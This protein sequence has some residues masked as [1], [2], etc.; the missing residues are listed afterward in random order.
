MPKIK[1]WRPELETLPREELEKLQL[2]HFR[3]QMKYV[4]EKSPFYR[5]KF[6]AAGVTPDDIK[7]MDDVRRVPFTTKQELLKSQEE[8]P[9]FGDFPCIRPEQATRV[10]Q[11][12]GTTG[13][14]LKIPLSKK[15][16]F[17]TY[18]EQFS[19]YLCGYGINRKDV[20]F[21]PFT[22]GTFIAWWGVQAV[23][24][25]HGIT[26][27]PGGGQTSDA[28]VKSIV[29]WEATVVCGT[30][31]YIIYLGEL[32]KKLG[33][34]LP[35]SKVRVVITAG[36]PGAQVAATKHLVESLYGAKNYDDIGST[37]ISNFGFECVVQKGTH[38]VESMFLPESLD[39]ETLKPVTEGEVG[40]LVLS[41]LFC[42][43]APLLRYM[44][45][46]LVRFNYRK[47]DC[48]R[49][50][51]RMDGGVLGRADDMF[52]FGGV[53]IFPSAV[54]NFIRGIPSFSN[55]YQLVIP[56]QGSGKRMIIRVEPAN[57]DMSD[58]QMRNAI[59]ELSDSIVYNIKITADIQ[60]VAPGTL[61]RF[62]G[63]AKRVI[64]AN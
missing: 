25:Q 30:P 57:G 15:D 36:E 39:T 54:E 32:A 13:K 45:K 24:E 7:T 63:K 34:D 28:R 26:I 1:M 27:V 53:N 16:W 35:N 18:Y 5:K 37:E 56:E 64:R 22:Y 48:G 59:K 62:E 31:T 8:H 2:K 3:K 52:T 12:S 51:L 58:Q 23:M 33:I 55:E 42:E 11:T 10:F 43:S 20:A 6:T 40:E 38:M 4:M 14:P 49:T 17:K 41:N 60:L 46:D 9:I 50:F 29:D 47:C 44:T 21:F 61:P 19:Y